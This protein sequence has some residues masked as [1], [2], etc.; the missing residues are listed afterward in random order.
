MS[1]SR[2][3]GYALATDHRVSASRK[4]A[5]LQAIHSLGQKRTVASSRYIGSRAVSPL[6]A[7]VVSAIPAVIGPEAGCQAN[8]L[9]SP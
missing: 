8:R 9:H 1:L 4:I 7:G 5:V 6:R 3:K 2:P